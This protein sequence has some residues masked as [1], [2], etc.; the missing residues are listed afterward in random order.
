MVQPTAYSPVHEF[1]ADEAISPAFPGSELD[2]EFNALNTTIDEILTNLAL[3]QRDDG[4]LANNVVT[5]DAIAVQAVELRHLSDSIRSNNLSSFTLWVSGTLYETYELVSNGGSLYKCVTDHTSGVFATD[6]AAGLWTLVAILPGGTG[7]VEFGSLSSITSVYNDKV[8]LG[9]ASAADAVTYDTIAGVVNAAFAQ[10]ATAG[11]ALGDVATHA[12]S[13]F[14][15]AAANLTTWAGLAPSANAQSLVTAAGYAA[16]RALL[17]LEAGT[18]FYS[19]AAANAAF[20]PLDADLTTWAG[21]TPSANAQSL[22][23]AANY[24]AMRTLLDLEAGTDFYSIS[25]ADAAFQPLDAD[26][27]ALAALTTTAAGRSALEIADPGADR[28]LAWDDTAGTVA[29]IALAALTD[30]AAPATGDYVLIYGAEGDLRKANWSTLP[31]AGGGIANVV[32]DTTPQLGGDLDLNTHVITGMVIGTDIQAFDADLTTWAGLTPS[33]NAQSLVTAADYAAMRALLDLEAGTDFYS[34]TAADAA[35]LALSGGTLSGTVNF[36]DNTLQRP[37]ILDYG[38]SVNAIG[39]IGGGTQD[40]DLTLGNVVTGTVDTS[41]TTFTFSNPPASGVSG[42]FTL[43]LTN[44]GSQ[45]VYW[46]VAVA[47]EAGSAPTL[48]AAGVDVLTFLTVD[49]GTTWYG[50]PA[51]LDMS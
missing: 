6:L 33:A 32:E 10:D 1:L 26:L 43:I 3:I 2:I 20:Q 39:S 13:E 46:P 5:P 14:Q 30:E 15:A 8:L 9:D 38:L 29:P 11:G 45:T 4:A 48:T 28:V 51:G 37:K 35:F 47:W 31:G 40:I 42:K 25:A 17:D 12:A 36:A 19:I 7:G 27:T 18:D 49:A 21:L 44:G 34:K 50:F 23:T 22:V 41:T 24:A 16:M